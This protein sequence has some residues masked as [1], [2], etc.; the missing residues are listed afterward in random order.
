[1]TG[2]SPQYC[3]QAGEF[4]RIYPDLEVVLDTVDGERAVYIGRKKA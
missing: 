1:M 3:V 4:R 2:I